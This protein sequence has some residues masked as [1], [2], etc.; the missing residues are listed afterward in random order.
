MQIDSGLG[1]G[2]FKQV[3]LGIARD[4]DKMSWALPLVG[5]SAPV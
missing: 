4:D 5:S 3:P 2:L 1:H